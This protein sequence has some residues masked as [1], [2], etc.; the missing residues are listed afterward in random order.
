MAQV[1]KRQ[2]QYR[3]TGQQSATIRYFPEAATQTFKRGD[4]VTLS[5]GKIAVAVAYT[6]GD[7][8]ASGTQILGMVDADATGVTDTSLPVVIADDHT[9]F[10]I[11]VFH[12]TPASAVPA[13]AGNGVNYELFRDNLGGGHEAFGMD[14]SETTDTK[15]TQVQIYQG[16]DGIETG[17]QYGRVWVK[18]MQAQRELG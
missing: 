14:I 13:V 17:V 15:V 1:F 3:T 9:E 5:S 4:F 7:P 16:K 6:T 10:L 11:N 18:V 2:G 12:P 8:V